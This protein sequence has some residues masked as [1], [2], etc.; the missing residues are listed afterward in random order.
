MGLCIRCCGFVAAVWLNIVVGLYSSLTRLIRFSSRGVQE[1][2]APLLFVLLAIT[3]FA[4]LL[5]GGV[6][7]NM[8][9]SLSTL[10]SSI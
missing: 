1:N 2:I 6:L 7:S 4:G 10:G 5:E 3:Y 9:K 8:L